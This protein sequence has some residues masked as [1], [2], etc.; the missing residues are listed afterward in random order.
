MT[1]ERTGRETRDSSC[2][3]DKAGPLRFGEGLP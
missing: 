1:P 3:A 2:P